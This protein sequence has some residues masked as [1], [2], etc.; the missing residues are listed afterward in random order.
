MNGIGAPAKAPRFVELDSL[1]GLAALT[2]VLYHLQ[3]FWAEETQPT[4][5]VVCALLV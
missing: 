3:L 4:S 5:K 1:R 2:V